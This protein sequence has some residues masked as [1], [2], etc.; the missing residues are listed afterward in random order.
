MPEP[1]EKKPAWES[2]THEHPEPLP[3]VSSSDLANPL[4]TVASVMTPQPRTCS[5]ASTVLEAVMTFRDAECGIVPVVEAGKPVG[6]LTDRD[7]ALALADHETDLARRPVSELMST[8]L[9]TIE[10]DETLDV[11]MNRL[12]A[13]GLRRLLVV[14]SEGLLQGI[15]SWTDLAPHLSE[16]GLGQVLGQI[17]EHR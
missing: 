9:V 1:H 5:L 3:L 7:V 10:P 4:L 14:D 16:R 13:H 12:G 8:D 17:V 11:A 6:V 15:L 2:P